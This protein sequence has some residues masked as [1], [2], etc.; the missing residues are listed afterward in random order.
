MIKFGSVSRVS[1]AD[2]DV[3]LLAEARYD[4]AILGSTSKWIVAPYLA[5]PFEYANSYSNESSNCVSDYANHVRSSAVAMA[6]LTSIVELSA[7]G[8]T[9]II[10]CYDFNV[11]ESHLATLFDLI[12]EIFVNDA[13][14]LMMVGG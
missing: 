2:G 3:L 1:E 14:D 12:E 7:K 4:E 5:V 8:K 11:N 10:S 13:P 9:C 6:V